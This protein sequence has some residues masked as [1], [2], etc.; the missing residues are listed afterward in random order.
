MVFAGMNLDRVRFGQRRCTWV[1]G[2]HRGTVWTRELAADAVHHESHRV[3][4]A[5]PRP[6]DI[7][8]LGQPAESVLTEIISRRARHRHRA[9]ASIGPDNAFG[10]HL[11][12][13]DRVVALVENA[14]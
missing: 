10:R 14:A 13:F 1:I 9:D 12:Q 4:T 6:D 3:A 7:T 8:A 11:R 5:T 2:M